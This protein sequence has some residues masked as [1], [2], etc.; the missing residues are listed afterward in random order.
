MK[1]LFIL[2]LSVVL[3]ACAAQSAEKPAQPAR[4]VNADALAHQEIAALIARAINQSSVQLSST[5][6][7]QSPDLFIAKKDL[8]GMQVGMKAGTRFSLLK[9]GQQCLLEGKDQ[10]WPLQHV[11]C[12]VFEP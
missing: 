9:Q 11:Q 7:E 5:M 10:R 4:M 12:V 2:I 3:L 1:T 6:F 8:T